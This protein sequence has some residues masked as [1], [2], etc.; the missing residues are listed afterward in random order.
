MPLA[1]PLIGVPACRRELPPHYFHVVGEKYITA[2]A[3]AA[4]GLPLLVPALG[5]ALDVPDLLQRVDGL[6]LTG[7]PSNVEPHHYEGPG[8]DP[9][10]WHDPHRDA[11]ALPLIRAV[12]DAGVPLFALCRGCQ[13]VNVALGGSLHQKVHE[14]PGLMDHR[15]D[16]SQPLDVQYG[17][18]HEV[19]FTE[20][21]FLER[22]TGERSAMVN[23][24][25]KQGIRRLGRGL[26]VEAVT[27]D[28]LIEALRVAEAPAF[29][30]AVQWHPEYKAVQ[31]ALSRI[32]FKAF[33]DACRERA[34]ERRGS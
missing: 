29:A 11:T 26:V 19:S 6:L 31:N 9:G 22:L 15:E 28:G 20:G 18:A 8:S 1:K 5:G 10:T 2:V 14:V 21:G 30:L 32:L 16:P 33:G 4:G 13:E 23:S 12:I 17:P 27:E 34:A 24:V 25:H 7:S 3:D